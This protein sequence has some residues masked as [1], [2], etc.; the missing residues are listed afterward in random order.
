MKKTNTIRKV[1]KIK[2]NIIDLLQLRNIKADTPIF[3]GTMNEQHIEKRH[4]YEYDKY[5]NDIENILDQPD[6]IG[7]N[8]KDNSITYVKEYIIASEYIR[9]GVKVSA[10]GIAYAKTLH[11]LSTYNA[12]RYIQKGTLIKIND[13]I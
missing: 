6:Y 3:I 12:E 5:F 8:P 10:K 2:Q 1:G 13:N 7:I 11:L 9:V 4:P